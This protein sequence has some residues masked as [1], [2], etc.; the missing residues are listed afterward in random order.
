MNKAELVEAVAKD[1]KLSKAG[2]EKAVNS[3]IN[4]IKK[5]TKKEGVQIVGFGSFT[6]MQRKA[7]SGRNPQT[8]EKIRIGAKKVVKFKPGAAFQKAI[9]K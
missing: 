7:R 8:G 4:T 1:T 2:V 5:K 9:K 6:S 3:M